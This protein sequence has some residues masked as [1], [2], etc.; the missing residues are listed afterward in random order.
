MEHGLLDARGRGHLPAGRFL[1]P[2]PGRRLHLD[3][4]L[5]PAMVRRAGQEAREIPHLQRLAA[6]SFG[7]VTMH[8]RP[9]PPMLSIDQLLAELTALAQDLR[10]RAAGGHSRSSSARRTSRTQ[11]RQRSFRAP[12]SSSRRP[13]R[14][15][16]RAV[17][18]RPSR[19]LAP[20]GTGSHIDAIPNAGLYDGCVGVLGGLE[21]IRVLQQSRFQ[22]RRSIEFVVFTA[23]EPTRFGI[24]C[25]GSRMMAGVLPPVTGDCLCATKMAEAWMNSAQQAGFTGSLDSV[26]L[27]CRTLPPVCRIAH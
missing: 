3:G 26:A 6:P 19:S 21:A 8:T 15:H 23:E 18:R 13:D 11:T 5:L 9:A 12:D 24:G 4:T 16:F 27:A 14:Q 10:S 17:G 25:L 20:V 2:R 22:P 1:V 7:S